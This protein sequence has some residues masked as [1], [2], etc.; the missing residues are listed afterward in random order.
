M[1]LYGYLISTNEL[2]HS[3]NKSLC[4]LYDRLRVGLLCHYTDSYNVCCTFDLILDQSISLFC[5]K[6][7]CLIVVGRS[8]CLDSAF[9]SIRNTGVES[10]DRNILI[11]S[12]LDRTDTSLGIERCK[13]DCCRL[14]CNRCIQI[15]N[16]LCNCGLVIR[17]LERN[18]CIK[19]LSRLHCTLLNRLPELVL[20]S[21]S[22][23]IDLHCLAINCFLCSFCL[24]LFL[25][26]SGCSCRC[27][28]L[29]L[30]CGTSTCCERQSHYARQ[31]NC[32]N[33]FFHLFSSF[34][35][36]FSYLGYPYTQRILR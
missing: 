10:N 36:F 11:H 14:L 27:C 32:H 7:S 3:L 2:C 28:S 4:S 33:S 15:L 17:S 31:C 5:R 9:R 25:S 34:K 6:L 20:E 1:S 23:N 24:L 16:L 13:T 19:I 26:G 29:S 12:I 30:S 8:I 35:P 21:L 22:D 18:L